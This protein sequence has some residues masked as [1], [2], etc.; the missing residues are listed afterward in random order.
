MLSENNGR[1]Y[2]KEK[3]WSD[4]LIPYIFMKN[5]C[6]TFYRFKV[7]TNGFGYGTISLQQNNFARHTI[8]CA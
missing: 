8:H 4:Y 6:I 3:H 5:I 7:L 2:A 1:E